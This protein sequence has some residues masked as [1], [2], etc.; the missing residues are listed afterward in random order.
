[1]C[2]FYYSLYLC[3]WN[4]SF[5]RSTQ[6]QLGAQWLYNKYPF[7][8]IQMASKISFY[9]TSQVPFPPSGIPDQTRSKLPG[10]HSWLSASRFQ[11]LFLA[12][13]FSISLSGPDVSAMGSQVLL[14][15]FLPLCL[16]LCGFLGWN[17][18]IP[19]LWLYKPNLPF[20]HSS[21]HPSIH[22]PTHPATSIHL[23]IHP[24]LHPHTSIHPSTHSFIYWASFMCK[25]HTTN[26]FA[27]PQIITTFTKSPKCLIPLIWYLSY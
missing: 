21:I 2:S 4:I 24:F 18:L 15:V 19:F 10:E 17:F 11:P 14:D 1:M 5:L 6:P 27:L 16:G 8:P 22:P 9:P 26:W 13:G 20:T 25:T 12:L 3:A 7:C 23:S